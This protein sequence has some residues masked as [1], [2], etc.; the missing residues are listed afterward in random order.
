MKLFKKTIYKIWDIF[1]FPRF[2]HSSE[3]IIPKG[4]IPEIVPTEEYKKRLEE[5]LKNINFENIKVYIDGK[6]RRWLNDKGN[7]EYNNNYF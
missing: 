1:N 3:I 7:I 5:C 4:K 6:Q 2:S